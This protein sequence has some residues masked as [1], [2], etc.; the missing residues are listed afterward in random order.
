M[1][2]ITAIDQS[3]KKW[4]YSIFWRFIDPLES[5]RLFSQLVDVMDRHI[6][7]NDPEKLIAPD[8]FQIFVN[9]TV[10][11]KHAHAV[12]KIEA[13][14]RDRLQKYV[15]NKDYELAQPKIELQII[16]SATVAKKDADIRCWF[17]SEE[18][19]SKE[20]PAKKYTLKVVSG[21]GKGLSWLLMAGKT[22]QIGRLSSCDICLPFQNV[23]KKQAEL[24]IS[25][26]G[27]RQ[28]RRPGKFSSCA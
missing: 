1:S 23:S 10:F 25:A 3:I 16:S 26:E 22:Y 9:N 6:D 19:A 7:A 8:H 20:V 21:E 15:A 13:V 4:I 18:E 12:K 27:S 24:K 11:I 14:V 2:L 28:E 17:S 5:D